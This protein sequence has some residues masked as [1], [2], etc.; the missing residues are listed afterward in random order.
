MVAVQGAA[1]AVLLVHTQTPAHTQT[2]SQRL[3]HRCESCYNGTSYQNTEKSCALGEE[4]P[5]HIPPV[6]KGFIPCQPFSS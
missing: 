6:N 4:P 3:T 2:Q 1:K 5:A